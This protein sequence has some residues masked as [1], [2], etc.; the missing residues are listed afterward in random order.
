MNFK[1]LKFK[2]INQCKRNIIKLNLKNELI[3]IK[4]NLIYNEV[5]KEIYQ[6]F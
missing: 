5:L 4:I 3:F 6:F 1:L 2:F